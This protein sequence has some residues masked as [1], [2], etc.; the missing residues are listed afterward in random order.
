MITVTQYRYEIKT[1]TTV[2]VLVSS[3]SDSEKDSASDEFVNLLGAC[4]DLNKSVAAYGV[5][6]F[7]KVSE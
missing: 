6:Y 2:P 4:N 1:N 7:V 5:V 3:Y